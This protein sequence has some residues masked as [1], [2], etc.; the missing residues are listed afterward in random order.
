MVARLLAAYRALTPQQ[1][2]PGGA[3]A[4]LCSLQL[5]Q[6]TSEDGPQSPSPEDH[7]S[8]AGVARTRLP[9]R[10]DVTDA[11]SRQDL[12]PRCPSRFP[13]SQA[14]LR[15]AGAGSPRA[16]SAGRG[17]F[18]GVTC[19]GHPGRLR[20]RGR[21]G[22]G[23]EPREESVVDTGP[24]P[25]HQSGGYHFICPAKQPVWQRWRSYSSGISRRTSSRGS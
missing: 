13:L 4:P 17:R 10:A 12:P 18:S 5:P 15:S 6:R 19:L 16:C 20:P 8:C 11:D 25:Q 23:E 1:A 9:V 7:P 22:P 21:R 3:G 24:S 2:K 14:G